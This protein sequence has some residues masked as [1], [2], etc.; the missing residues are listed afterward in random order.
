MK[1]G[2]LRAAL[3]LK[4]VEFRTPAHRL[5]AIAFIEN[6][7]NKPE[8]NHKNGI[9]WD[10]K[11]SNLEWVTKSENGLHA[12]QTGL[13][14]ITEHNVQMTISRNKERNGSKHPL[15]IPIIDIVTGKEYVSIREAAKNNNIKEL[16]LARQLR[17]YTKNNNTNLKYKQL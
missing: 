6:P 4:G 8:V 14:K 13:N 7:E 15:S 16:T 10:N 3:Y 17:G 9:K 2:Y 1:D 5:V 12:F 11:K